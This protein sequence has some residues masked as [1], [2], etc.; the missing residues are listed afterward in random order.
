M[1]QRRNRIAEGRESL[2]QVCEKHA[3]EGHKSE[4]D[5]GERDRLG[6]GVEDGLGGSV[7]QGRAQ[8]PHHAKHLE[9]RSAHVAASCSRGMSSYH[10]L[11]RYG[12][13]ERLGDL[14]GV[15]ADASLSASDGLE[16][17][18]QTL[19]AAMT[20]SRSVRMTVRPAVVG[21]SAR[22]PPL[23]MQCSIRSGPRRRALGRVLLGRSPGILILVDYGMLARSD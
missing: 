10:K 12:R 20:P 21:V 17:I 3:P 16:R 6:V 2:R 14:L 9:T 7:G 13:F 4:L 5:N 18:T 15:C 1:S 19:L 11:D 22:S 8:V 23:A